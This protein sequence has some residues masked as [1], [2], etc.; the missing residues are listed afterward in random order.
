M[1]YTTET[2]ALTNA[3]TLAMLTAAVAKAEAL[4]QPQCIVIVDASGEPLG[5]IRMSGAKFLS[6]KSAR[7][8][9]R[10]AASIRAETS[11]IPEAVRP[12]IAAATE[13]EVTAL[14]G[15]LPIRMQGQIVG[16]IGVGSGTPE[17][18]IAVARAA[19]EAIGAA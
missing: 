11:T 5:E 7:A 16:G 10:T 17:Q 6:R 1:E 15:G 14:G 12:L 2:R 9:A 8:K 4:G 13:G 18:D 3:A 19:L